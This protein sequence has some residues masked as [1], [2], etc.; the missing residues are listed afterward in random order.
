MKR[1]LVLLP[2]IFIA[3]L[4]VGQGFDK[5]MYAA[6]KKFH[7]DSKKAGRSTPKKQKRVSTSNVGR[8]AAKESKSVSTLDGTKKKK[9]RARRKT[10]HPKG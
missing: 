7:K 2:L 10:R 5:E 6:G 3:S 8:S 4:C 1:I 9:N